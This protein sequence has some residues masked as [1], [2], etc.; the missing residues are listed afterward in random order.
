DFA[1]VAIAVGIELGA[2]RF[3]LDH[4][5]VD[6]EAALDHLDAVARHADD[7]L[8][9]FHVL[10]NGAEDGNVTAV[11]IAAKDAALNR[12]FEIEQGEIAIAAEREG[13]LSVTPD[14]LVGDEVVADH[15]R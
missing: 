4:G 10:R 9:V 1:R 14:E 7:A 8:D 15:Q 2:Q 12:Q 6:V 13:M 11:R 5:A 3:A